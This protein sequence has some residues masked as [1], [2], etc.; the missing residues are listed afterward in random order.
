MQCVGRDDQQRDNPDAGEVVLQ[1]DA[2]VFGEPRFEQQNQAQ[3]KIAG[4]LHIQL[5]IE[6][7]AQRIQSIVKT[8]LPI[9]RGCISRQQQAE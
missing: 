2:G 6:L 1:N 8:V 7:V 4:E 3:Q 5:P 9:L